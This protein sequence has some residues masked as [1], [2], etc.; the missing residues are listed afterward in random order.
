LVSTKF[1]KNNEPIIQYKYIKNKLDKTLGIKP[2][3][4]QSELRTYTKVVVPF[5][6][7]SNP[8]LEVLKYN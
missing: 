2:I 4:H 7:A 8:P 3:I 6:H 1:R 5:V